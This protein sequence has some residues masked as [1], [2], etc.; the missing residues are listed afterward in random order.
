MGWTLDLITRDKTNTTSQ[1]QVQTMKYSP[2]P[3]GQGGSVTVQSH[4]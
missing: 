4:K 2:V 3:L 1:T